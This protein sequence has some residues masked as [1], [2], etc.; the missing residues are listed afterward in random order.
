MQSTE[1]DP[2]H[3]A[4]EVPVWVKLA[5]LVFGLAGIALAYL[6]LHRRCPGCPA[7]TAR[8]FPADLP[9]FFNKWYFDELYDALFV[10]PGARARPLLLEEGRR[11]HR[12][13]GSAPTASPR[14]PR[15]WRGVLSRFQTGYVYHYAFAMLI[16]VVA[17]R[18]L[19]SCCA[20]R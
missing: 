20:A 16:G 19:V 9:L 10:Q 17:P 14:A 5:P 18:H 7:L 3:A 4:H 6:Y 1:H 12:S 13:T 8:R 2:S 11:R 15:T